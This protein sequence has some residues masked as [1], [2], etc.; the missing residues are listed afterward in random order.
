[1]PCE[2]A[3]RLFD[4]WSKVSDKRAFLHLLNKENHKQTHARVKEMRQELSR[5][6]DE[7]FAQAS[8][9]KAGCSVCQAEVKPA[10]PEEPEEDWI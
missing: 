1:M 7:L 2:E 6:A 10:A 3:E 4:E 5:K 8:T 9:H